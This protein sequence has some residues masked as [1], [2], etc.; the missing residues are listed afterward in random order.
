MPR[1]SA[2]EHGADPSRCII[3]LIRNT[4]R[5]ASRKYWDQISRQLEPIYT[6]PTIGDVE[7]ARDDFLDTWGMRLPRHPAAMPSMG[8][9]AC[10]Q[11]GLTRAA[12]MHGSYPARAS[13]NPRP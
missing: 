10:A 5:Y 8:G 6:A 12:R 4:F 9:G 13:R 1:L 7:R 3:H 11:T 2:R